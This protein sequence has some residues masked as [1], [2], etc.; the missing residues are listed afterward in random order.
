[1]RHSLAVL[2]AV[3]VIAAVAIPAVTVAQVQSQE[4]TVATGVVGALPGAPAVAPVGAPNASP[5]A[6]ASIRTYTYQPICELR[7]EQ[8]QDEY[9]WR[10]RDIRVCR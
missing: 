7:R 1:M 6:A 2:P 9:G 10:V 4:A 8:F 5:F 3:L